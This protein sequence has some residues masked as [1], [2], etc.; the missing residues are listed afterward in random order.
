LILAGSKSGKISFGKEVAE[1]GRLSIQKEYRQAL[2][3]QGQE[4][5]AVF[6][7]KRMTDVNEDTEGSA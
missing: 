5:L 1:K 3:I 6:E 4:V 7:I 2:T